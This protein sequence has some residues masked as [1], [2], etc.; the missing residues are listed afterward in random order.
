[1]IQ[2][3]FA[4]DE[5]GVLTAIESID[6]KHR[7]DH[8]YRCPKC[9]R[10]MRPRL[11]GNRTKHFYHSDNHECSVESYIHYVGKRLLYDRFYSEKPLI[12]E[13]E[14]QVKC[15]LWN[16]CTVRG[17][18]YGI[19]MLSPEKVS[20]D[21]KEYY[22]AAVL[23]KEWAG[24][25]PDVL[26]TSSADPSRPPFFLE[27]C[28]RHPCTVEKRNSGIQI[29]EIK[30]SD[31]SELLRLKD[32]DVIAGG[33]PYNLKEGSCGRD[34]LFAAHQTKSLFPCT[35][36]YQLEHA[37]F[38]RVSF[39][40]SGETS[41]KKVFSISDAHDE[42]A[43][44]EITHDSSWSKYHRFSAVE[45]ISDKNSLY[46]N[47]YCCVHCLDKTKKSYCNQGLNGSINTGLIDKFKAR[48]CNSYYLSG[49]YPYW[50]G[51]FGEVNED[52]GVDY[53][54]FVAGRDYDL[55]LNPRFPEALYPDVK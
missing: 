36:E 28:F 54:A 43:V 39:Y 31:V 4:L 45:M 17:W 1:M 55:W 53:E 27:V 14:R 33:V 12:V 21:L 26:L 49:S 25:R 44:F 30:I 51:F 6:V 9:G 40:Q 2:Y 32:E 8:L 47:C 52:G 46:R 19:C 42:S 20:L 13:Y 10:E 38:I 7:H 23:E 50:R 18:N 16:Q 35:K 24:F 5:S 34:R 48:I 3:P 22:D 29:L 15:E 11:G 41:Q 37:P